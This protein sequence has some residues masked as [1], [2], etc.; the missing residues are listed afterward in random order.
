MAVWGI[1]NH[2]KSTKSQHRYLEKGFSVIKWQL[3][4]RG[5]WPNSFG[6]FANTRFYFKMEPR[7]QAFLLLGQVYDKGKRMASLP[8]WTYVPNWSEKTKMDQLGLFE[9]WTDMST[10]TFPPT[11]P[12]CNHPILTSCVPDLFQLSFGLPSLPFQFRQLY[13]LYITHTW[14]LY[15]RMKYCCPL[16]R[17]SFS[18]IFYKVLYDKFN[19]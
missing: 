3:R 16:L 8:F 6:G 10:N 11:W 1:I 5:H 7:C 2:M 4:M 15:D 9:R 18:C 17:I 13:F 19:T 12:N 14:S